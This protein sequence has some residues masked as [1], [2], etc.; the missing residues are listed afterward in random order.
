MNIIVTSR[1]ALRELTLDDAPFILELLNEPD[2]I[3]FIGDRGVRDIASAQEYITKGP[4]ASYARNK[5]GLWLVQRIDSGE[6]IGICGLIKREVLPD[7]D[8]GYAYLA[9]FRSQG[10]AFEA[11]SAVKD[12]ATHTLNLKRLLGVTDPDN[13]KSQKVLEKIGLR[14]ERLVKLSETGSELMLF[15]ADYP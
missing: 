15:A 4:Q 3:R 1:L 2:F 7:V 6:S 8:I 11:A 13:S 10:Y 9:R 12:Y 14:F 5:F